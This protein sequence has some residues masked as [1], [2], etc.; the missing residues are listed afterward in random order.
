[1]IDNAIRIG[2]TVRAVLFSGVAAVGLALPAAAWAQDAGADDGVEDY[3]NEIVVTATKREQTLQEVP[4]AVSVTS[5]ELIERAQIRDIKDLSSV[6]PS[7]RVGERQNS[8]NTNF[9][10]RGFGNGA[11]NAGIE[12]SVG[13]FVDGVYRSRSA[14]Q[15]TD[16]PDVQRVEVLRG[17]QSTL[18]GK[19]ASAGVISIVTQKPKFNFGGNVEASYGNF[20]AIVV[21]GL[22][23]GPIG[24]D[25]AASFAAGVNKR[26]GMVKNLGTGGDTQDR[27]RWF[28]RGQ[29]LYEPDKT[30]SMRLIADYSKIDE[31]CCAVVNLKTGPATGVLV[32]PLIGGKVNPDSDP[33]GNVIYTNFDSTNKVKN[34]GISGQIDYKVG[35]FT[36]TSISA[37]RKSLTSAN[38]D[39]DFTSADMARGANIGEVKIRTFTQELRLA[40]S[41]SDRI[42][43]L[44]GAFYFNEKVAQESDIRWGT[45]ARPYF[46]ALVRASSNNTNNLAALEGLFGTLTGN[47][48]R[49]A[50]Q[51]FA[52]GQG[53]HESDRLH[54]KNYS[55]FGQMDF[56]ITDQL[57]F[58]GGLNYTNDKKNF[59]VNIVST[60]V[61]GGL[62]LPALRTAA[63]NAGIAQTIGGLLQVPG[64]FASAAQIAGFAQAQPAAFAQI[65][66][67]AANATLP[68]L[69]LRSLQIFTPFLGIPNAVEPGKTKDDKLT[70]TARLAYDVNNALNLYAS[71]AT[72]YK[73][74]SVALS[75]DSRPF[76]SDRAAITGA[77]IGVVNQSYGT[78]FAG[79]ESSSVYEL[80]L[81]GNWDLGSI[82]IAVFHQAIKGFQSNI[83]TGLGFVLGNAGKQSVKGFE[84]EGV[85]RPVKPLSLGLAA[86]YLKPKYNDFKQSAFG[87]ATGVRPADIPAWSITT[88]LDYD[89]AL[90]SDDHLLLHVDFHFESDTQTIEGLP[91]FIVKNPITGAVID[92]APG[93]AAA[94]P[95]R[96]QVDE[97]NAS[98][99]YAMQNGIE[100]SV[101]GRN[102][103]NDRYINQIFDSVAQNGSVSGYVNARRTYGLAARYRW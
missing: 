80:G 6:V 26:D 62:D 102:L 103:T 65:Q 83:F 1:M 5:G 15:I 95:F 92:F 29:L 89:H 69:G 13:V 44:A 75:R 79:P 20:D 54:D 2:G 3:G 90:P 25:V 70:Y 68:L 98:L 31:K 17:P 9:F 14:A 51:F 67:G 78:R 53:F 101:W 40:G 45:A 16:L 88:S 59:G 91:G 18:F 100:V 87:D 41:V 4:V 82:N 85:L 21:K 11:N 27:D 32:S 71:Y 55:L 49:Y 38:F 63:T 64:G 84:F 36:I 7:L 10:I 28:T 35:D 72:G 61:F 73:A 12:P 23:T 60:D 22:V 42:D 37:W 47:P 99:T 34:Y 8:T 96:R 19:N 81:K 56:H 58:T 77:G 86:T 57:T 43:V 76:E 24:Q 30:L 50:G 74:S 48:A 93:L 39:T 97:L 33:F 46:D 66:T 94:R 52:A